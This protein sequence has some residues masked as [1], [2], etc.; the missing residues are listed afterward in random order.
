MQ[1][2]DSTVK[3]AGKGLHRTMWWFDEWVSTPVIS[4]LTREYK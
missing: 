4:V 3:M 2:A 1:F